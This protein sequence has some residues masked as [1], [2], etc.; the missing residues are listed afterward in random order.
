[1]R[2]DF[3]VELSAVLVGLAGQGRKTQPHVLTAPGPDLPSRAFDPDEHRTLERAIR[4]WVEGTTG[5]RLGFVE[6]LYTFGDRARDTTLSA[7]APHK[8]SIGYLAVVPMSAERKPG[9]DWLPWGQF[10]PWEDRRDG[11]S[12][13]LTEA[14]LPRLEAM[15]LT[16]TQRERAALSFGLAGH[17][18]RDELVLERYELM[19]SLGLVPEY[20]I[21]RQRPIPEDL[22]PLGQHLAADHRR[23]FATGIGRLRAKLKYRPV[24][25]DL[26]P[27][28]FTLGDLQDAAEAVTGQAL[29]KQNFRRMITGSGLVEATGAEIRRAAGRPAAEYRFAQEAEWDH[30]VSTVRFGGARR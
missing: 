16:A 2:R 5:L 26:M 23:V 27:E 28:T 29:H 20:Y 4:D 30:K 19:Y 14:I 12:P 24:L 1:M 6:Q 17:A 21:D 10:F 25:F 13:I 11:P 8:V 7:G 3:V 15:E 18:W 22:P 9:S